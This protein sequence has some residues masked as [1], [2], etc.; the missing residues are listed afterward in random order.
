MLKLVSFNQTLVAAGQKRSIS[1]D[2]STFNSAEFATSKLAES[3]PRNPK[4][5]T[6][7]DEIINDNDQDRDVT[8]QKTLRVLQ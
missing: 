2:I 6:L 7:L 4:I 3:G 8:S 5:Q 1:T